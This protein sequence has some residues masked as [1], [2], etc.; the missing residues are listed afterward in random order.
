ML[1]PTRSR[2]ARATRD[3]VR[4]PPAPRPGRAL[5]AER[6]VFRPVVGRAGASGRSGP[7]QPSKATAAP[8]RQP[9]DLE[10][11]PEQ[12]RPQVPPRALD[13][14]GF[15]QREP[16]V[17]LGR[18]RW[19]HV[20][21][22]AV[23]RGEDA[24]VESIASALQPGLRQRRTKHGPAA[25]LQPTSAR[26]SGSGRA[27]PG[28]GPPRRGPASARTGTAEATARSAPTAERSSWAAPGRPGVRPPRPSP[29]HRRSDTDRG[30]C[31]GTGVP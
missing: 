18:G 5:G 26:T 4:A 11:S 12:I 3:G 17:R 20:V 29:G 22:E 23:P 25:A 21:S 27:R 19:D 10:H 8:A 16:R 7:R 30:P 15:R 31:S 13:L 2:A 24:V 6:G 28:A 14:R 1:E 9:V